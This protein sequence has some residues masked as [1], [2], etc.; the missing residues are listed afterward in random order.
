MLGDLGVGRDVVGFEVAVGLGVAGDGGF[1]V[2]DDVALRPG[3]RPVD[4]VVDAGPLLVRARNPRHV[5]R[6]EDD[7]DQVALVEVRVDDGGRIG[8]L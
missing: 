3:A 7:R 2:H 5:A 1:G 8:R 6:V 4:A